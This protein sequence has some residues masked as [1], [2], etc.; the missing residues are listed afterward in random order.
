MILTEH[1]GTG[2]RHPA[3]VAARLVPVSQLVGDRTEC[4]RQG[5]HERLAVA[6]A[7]LSGGDRLL[8]HPSRGG[9]LAGFPM[10]AG[11]QVGGG[12]HL[13]VIFAEVCLSHL[14]PLLQ[15]ETGA[16]EVAVAPQR[17]GVLLDGG[18]LCGLR[19]PVMLPGRRAT[20]QPAGTGRHCA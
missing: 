3:E 19:H 20:R 1:G 14:Q 12:E 11:E 18:Q 5:Q 13:R 7:Q 16:G 17:A 10:H 4:V 6:V 15:H 9:R 2:G 8:Q